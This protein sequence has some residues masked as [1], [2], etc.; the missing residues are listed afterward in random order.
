M[1]TLE[2]AKGYSTHSRVHVVACI[3]LCDDLTEE[4]CLKQVFDEFCTYE[5]RM[6]EPHA[7]ENRMLSGCTYCRCLLFSA[8]L[9]REALSHNVSATAPTS[10]HSPHTLMYSCPSHSL[11]SCPSHSLYSCPS[12]SL[13][14]YPSHPL[15]SCPSAP[16]TAVYPLYPVYQTFNPIEHS[17]CSTECNNLALLSQS[18]T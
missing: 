2:F 15:Y 4:S 14:C 7:L 16:C 5:L 8:H 6:C 11:Y 17:K 18:V 13:H 12:H 9:A 3:A 10:P 1:C